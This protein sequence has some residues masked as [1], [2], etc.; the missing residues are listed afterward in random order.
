MD[1][2]LYWKPMTWWV[3]I[4]PLYQKMNYW[5]SRKY[6]TISLVMSLLRDCLQLKFTEGWML[7]LYFKSKT[8]EN[9]TAADWSFGVL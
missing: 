3:D 1:N 5:A 6:A 9:G 4:N 8:A 2:T 7:Y